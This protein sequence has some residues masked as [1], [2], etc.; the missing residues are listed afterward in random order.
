MR[1]C[2]AV[3]GPRASMRY[4]TIISPWLHGTMCERNPNL[5]HK[6]IM[7]NSWV[8]RCDEVTKWTRSLFT[9]HVLQSLKTSTFQWNKQESIVH[10]WLCVGIQRMRRD[11]AS[12]AWHPAIHWIISAG[13][14]QLVWRHRGLGRVL[15]RLTTCHLVLGGRRGP[16]GRCSPRRRS[17]LR[18]PARQ[19]K[20]AV[21]QAARTC[22][23]FTH[24]LCTFCFVL[25][26]NAEEL[27]N[28]VFYRPTKTKIPLTNSFTF[29]FV[30]T[31]R[32]Y[33]IKPQKSPF[34]WSIDR[35]F[36][37]SINRSVNR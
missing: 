33:W 14:Q 19:Q 32:R 26:S 25:V 24:S 37:P 29:S 18:R 31:F 8:A 11:G 17:P 34:Q 23:P 6:L 21:L 5:V 1:Y 27:G 4:L 10:W 22:L 3:K 30:S 2:I 35:S 36:H 15:F 12:F 28:G 9:W 7:T 16:R 20:A 13:R